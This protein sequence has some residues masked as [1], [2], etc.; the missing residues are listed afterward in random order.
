[1]T[2]FGTLGIKIA[3]KQQAGCAAGHISIELV[4]GQGR[5]GQGGVGR[6]GAGQGIAKRGTLVGYSATQ[7]S[8]LNQVLN[9]EEKLAQHSTPVHAVPI[10]DFF[11]YADHCL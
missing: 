4:V 1:M 3:A 9:S 10:A 11:G 2:I 5:A 8:H 7:T 6:G